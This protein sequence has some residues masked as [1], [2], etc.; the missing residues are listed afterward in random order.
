MKA[1]ELRIGNY[2]LAF[3]VDLK[4]VETLTKDKI[5]ID[6]QPIPLTEEWLE[7]FGFYSKYKS[8]NNMWNILGFDIQQISDEDDDGNKIP[9]EQVFYYQY[10]YDIKH[11]HQLQNLYFALTGEELTIKQ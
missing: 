7:K 9:Q 5:L 11:V 8:C 10:R 3:G 2:Y 1:T 6:F 4:Q